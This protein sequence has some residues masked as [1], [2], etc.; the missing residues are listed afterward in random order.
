MR[1]YQ[2]A[3]IA[4]SR[5][6][7]AT[8]DG[9]AVV[10]IPPGTGAMR[11]AVR[12][13]AEVDAAVSLVLVHR[14]DQVHTTV[15]HVQDELPA[16][17]VAVI[18][19]AT[20]PPLLAQVLVA[21]VACA[22]RLVADG[23]LR[24]DDLGLVVLHECHRSVGPLLDGYHGRL[25]G[26]TD[27]PDPETLGRLGVEQP[28]FFYSF[29]EAVRDGY[30]VGFRLQSVASTVDTR[31]LPSDLLDVDGLDS[32]GSLLDRRW[33]L[34]PDLARRVAE[35]LVRHLGRDADGLPHK[36]VVAVPDQALAE[37]VTTVLNEAFAVSGI[38]ARVSS[39]AAEATSQR[40]RTESMPR[41][42]VIVDQYDAVRSPAIRAV[43]LLRPVRSLRL[44]HSLLCLGAR[45]EMDKPSFTLFDYV[46]AVDSL[47]PWF[48]G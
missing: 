26:L 7:L 42:A 9:R 33:F 19:D 14:R 21:T 12:I 17:H 43:V 29:A 31:R 32:F 35:D 40:F 8:P 23:H 3:A 5:E 1:P 27:L 10:A 13:L 37:M 16:V 11:T 18:D 30:L 39:G 20:R 6:A 4:R 45:P 25:L 28:A 22:R 36:A 15:R 34:F 41:I 24:L 46:G 2:V 48:E 38:A 44:L 47:W